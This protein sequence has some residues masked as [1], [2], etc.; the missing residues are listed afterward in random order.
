MKDTSKIVSSRLRNVTCPTLQ[1]AAVH[2]LGDSCRER[3]HGGAS[4]Y[5]VR[6]ARL[7]RAESLI[8]AERRRVHTHWVASESIMTSLVWGIP[9]FIGPLF[10]MKIFGLLPSEARLSPQK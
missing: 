7:H 9:E 5:S 3:H 4:R 1:G 8:L 2:L 10:Q 6:S